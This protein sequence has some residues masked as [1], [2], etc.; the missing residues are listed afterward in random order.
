MEKFARR[1]DITGKGMSEGW[2][3][4]DGV[5][6]TSTEE[7][8]LQE[9]RK[10]IENGSYGWLDLPREELLEMSDQDLLELG[11]EEDIFYYTEWEELDDYWYDADGNEYKQ[12]YGTGN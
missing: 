9:F 1:C 7:L 3:W 10:D 11:L 6:Y 4:G 12:E 8:T 5:F 2:V